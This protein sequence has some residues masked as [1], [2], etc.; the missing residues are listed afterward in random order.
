MHLLTRKQFKSCGSNASCVCQKGS[1]LKAVE[2]L[3]ESGIEVKGLA[4]IFTYGFTE[5]EKR[6]NEAECAYSTLT[7]YTTLLEKALDSKY[8]KKD[9][10]DLLREWRRDPSKWLN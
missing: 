7:D 8:I 1:S 9:H 10:L 6:F 5:S 4:A 2:S 3:R